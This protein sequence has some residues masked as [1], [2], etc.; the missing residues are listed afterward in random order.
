MKR[1]C[2]CCIAGS[3]PPRSTKR[4]KGPSD[5]RCP[6]AMCSP[7]LQTPGVV[8]T[9]IQEG[10]LPAEKWGPGSAW[11]ITL[12]TTSETRCIAWI[13]TS[14]HLPH[15]IRGFIMAFV[16]W[17]GRCAQLLAT[18]YDHGASH[19]VLLAHLAPR[20]RPRHNKRGSISPTFS[21][22]GPI[23]KYNG[24]PLNN[25]ARPKATRPGR[26]TRAL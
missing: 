11:A 13:M 23:P 14:T 6:W 10:V 17:R 21:A 1:S 5:F 12:D 20:R 15:S 3:G 18:V 2:P 25:V 7:I 26:G 8:Y 4:R 19:Q 24:R 9:W 22:N 16:R